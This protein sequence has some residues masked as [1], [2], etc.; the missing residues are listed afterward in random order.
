MLKNNLLD[1]Q[2]V[3][4]YHREYLKLINFYQ[5]FKRPSIFVRYYNVNMDISISDQDTNSTYDIYKSSRIVFDIYDLT[6]VYMINPLVNATNNVPDMA[7]QM[8]ESTTSI[9]VYTIRRPRINDIVTFYSPVESNEIYRVSNYRI[10]INMLYAGDDSVHIYEL[11]LE[12]A[13]FDKTDMLNIGQSFVYDLSSEKYLTKDQYMSYI[14]KLDTYHEL[15]NEYAKFYDHI[16]DLYRSQTY[17]PLISNQ[18]IYQFKKYYSQTHTRLFDNIYSPFG[19]T[20]FLPQDDNIDITKINHN[21]FETNTYQIYNIVTNS[22][23]THEIDLE[24]Y[25]VNKRI[26]DLTYLIYLSKRLNDE[27]QDA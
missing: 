26:T 7:G 23:E 5:N 12:I 4:D 14:R 15:L 3:S 27:F 16:R 18:V 2:L 13:P 11:D 25:D 19:L 6:P 8:F 22:F 24:N 17:I 10:P 1:P 21:E 20:E 9:V